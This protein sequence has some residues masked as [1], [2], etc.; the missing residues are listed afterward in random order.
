MQRLLLLALFFF[1]PAASNLP[2]RAY[3]YFTG[4]ND[5]STVVGYQVLLIPSVVIPILLLIT[6]SSDQVMPVRNVWG[7]RIGWAMFLLFVAGTVSFIANIN[8]E[9]V[10]LFYIA[11]SL[12]PFLIYIA[13]RGLRLSQQDCDSI[14]KALA[15]GMMFP[16][17]FGLRA[18][19]QAWGIPSFE[20]LQMS[21]Y[22]IARMTPYMNETFGNTGN[23][24]A[25]LVLVGATLLAFVLDRNRAKTLRWW[26][27][28][29]LVLLL[30]HV[31][32]VSSRTAFLVIL[33]LL[34]V[35]VYFRQPSKWSIAAIGLS[36][37]LVVSQ[38]ALDESKAAAMF[39]RNLEMALRLDQHRDGSVRE[40]VSS[41]N[42]G[43]R[44]FKDHPFTGVGPGASRLFN[45]HAAAHQFNISQA[46]EMGILGLASSLALFVCVMARAIQIIRNGSRDQQNIQQFIFIMGP[47][48]YLLFGFIGAIP[49]TTGIVNTWITLCA[50]FLA[51]T[52]YHPVEHE[53]SQ[54]TA[55]YSGYYRRAYANPAPRSS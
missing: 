43:W 54:T 28:V 45:T 9:L 19:Y 15:L 42:E 44:L 2:G 34:P 49:L 7:Q 46:V 4:L 20:T 23:T 6:R 26:M 30:M 11:G 40:R 52:E 3:Y 10:A 51:L 5:I 32:I 50:A 21:R 13:L 16:L 48:A 12:A 55:A 27:C 14:M 17:L 35:F 31:A 18:Y 39:S 1:L 47:V 37:L 8:T 25:L 53:A 29:P 41:I 33:V 38:S 22:Y 36:L 24:A